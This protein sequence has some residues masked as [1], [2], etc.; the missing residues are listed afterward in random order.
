[1]RLLVLGTEHP[2]RQYDVV[3]NSSEVDHVAAIQCTG[4][5]RNGTKMTLIVL[6]LC[7]RLISDRTALKNEDLPSI[8]GEMEDPVYVDVCPSEVQKGGLEL[9]FNFVGL[10]GDNDDD[11]M[12]TNIVEEKSGEAE[13]AKAN[14]WKSLNLKMYSSSLRL[15]NSL[16]TTSITSSL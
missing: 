8:T 10:E 3:R 15:S 2:I 12:E 16:H 4:T 1:M 9:L 13:L 7:F 5:A 11:L 6:C 14:N